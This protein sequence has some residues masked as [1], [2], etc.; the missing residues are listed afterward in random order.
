MGRLLPV[1]IASARARRWREWLALGLY[2]ALLPLARAG[3]V[4]G[5]VTEAHAQEG[6]QFLFVPYPITEP[7][8]GNGLLAGPVWMRAGPKEATGPSKPQAFGFGALWT[9]GGSR[10]L[11]A[12]DRRAWRQGRWWTTALAADADVHLTYDG[13]SPQQEQGLGF[14]LR[15]RG[16]S[17]E[18]ERRLGKAG[19]SLGIRLF[20]TSVATD[21]DLGLPAELAG[22]RAEDRV[23]GLVVAWTQDTRDDLYTPATGHL[24]VASL[25]TY[26][27]WLGGSFDARTLAL[28]WTGYRKAP[29]KGAVGMRVIAES[30][31][32]DLPFFLRPYLAFRGLPALRYAGERVASFEGE[33]RRPVSPRWDVLAFAGVGRAWA[34]RQGIAGAKTVSA[35][36]L[37]V[38][39]KAQKYFGLTFGVDFAQGPDG[40]V[41][42]IQIGNAWGR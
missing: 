41:S 30:S 20:A 27:S 29:G 1:G 26:A 28:R 16:A 34:D 15:V 18:G 19:D 17:V 14:A 2:A 24:A 3:D 23:N 21:F 22:S 38:R 40:L 42:Y 9:D 11:L 36:G 13:L 32:G 39:F 6:S 25:T 37:G 35:A 5:E 31:G 7:A 10:G 33:Y 12:F 8:I 4:V